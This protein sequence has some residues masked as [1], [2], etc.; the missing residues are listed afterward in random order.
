MGVVLHTNQNANKTQAMFMLELSL[1]QSKR[2]SA[3]KIQPLC[4][5]VQLG[6][7][8]HLRWRL[9]LRSSGCCF[10]VSFIEDEICNFAHNS[11]TLKGNYLNELNYLNE[12]F[13][14]IDAF[15]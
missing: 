7:H 1:S 9:H 4:Y 3:V 13:V 6:S 15:L 11:N 10:Q 12:E 8:V 5:R 2:S 14:S